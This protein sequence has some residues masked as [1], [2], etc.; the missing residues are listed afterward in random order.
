MARVFRPAGTSFS[1]FSDTVGIPDMRI[2]SR[3]K[4]LHAFLHEP[5]LPVP[6]PLPSTRRSPP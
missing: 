3:E 4:T 6:D 2:L 1:I 5:L